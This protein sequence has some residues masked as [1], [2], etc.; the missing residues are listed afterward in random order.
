MFI[1]NTLLSQ[2]GPT[3]VDTLNGWELAAQNIAD[4][5]ALTIDA[6]DRP[7]QIELANILS[8]LRHAIVMIKAAAKSIRTGDPDF[9]ENLDNLT[10]VL[11]IIAAIYKQEA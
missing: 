8:T 2:D 5:I 3:K 9:Q 4:R 6:Q 11:P 10:P 1:S 7:R